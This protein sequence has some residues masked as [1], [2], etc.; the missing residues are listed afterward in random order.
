MLSFDF[1]ESGIGETTIVNL[2]DGSIGLVDACPS[3]LAKRPTI[4][5]LIKGRQIRFICLTHPHEDHYADL[6]DV[7]R[8]SPPDEFWHTISDTQA[9]FYSISEY[10]DFP[11]TKEALMK[12]LVKR[13]KPLIDIFHDCLEK[14]ITQIIVSDTS[15]FKIADVEVSF[16]A[17]SNS[18]LSKYKYAMQKCAKGKLKVM[19][20]PNT[21]SSAVVFHYKGFTFIHGGDVEAEQWKSAVHTAHQRN[22][23]HASVFKIPHHGSQNTLSPKESENFT[24]LFSGKTSTVI[25]GNSTHPALNVFRILSEKSADMYFLINR[26]SSSNP[27]GIPDAVCLS[28]PN[29]CNEH[30]R[31]EI[32]DNGTH[33]FTIGKGCAACGRLPVCLHDM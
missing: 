11:S 6:P 22:L 20:S 15:S 17:P 23:P 26:F 18:T 4:S 27:L 9:F 31:L 32:D 7:F 10:M 2:P 8:N 33:L 25:F 13:T 14:N 12:I 28:T 5:E 30:V 1:Y 21:I 3:T 29:I 24:T 16:L 19:P